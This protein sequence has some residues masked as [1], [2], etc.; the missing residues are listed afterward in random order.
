M[1]RC[2][3]FAA[4]LAAFGLVGC[5]QAEIYSIDAPSNLQSKIDSIA[6]IAVRQKEI[7]D[8]IAA[9]EAAAMEARLIDD[10]YQVGLTD[11]SSGWWGGHSKYYR[12]ATN[13]DTV[14]VKFKNFTGAKNV[15][16][17][18]VQAITSD[19]AR[20][21]EGYVEYAIWR[22]DNFSNYAWG[23][24]NG[25]GWNT[26]TAGDTH[27]TQQ[28]TSYAT[29][30]TANEDFTEYMNLMNGA[31]CIAS[32]TRGGDSVYVNVQMTSLS[33]TKLTKSFYIV[34]SGIQDKPIRVF[35]TLENCHLV[36]YKTL[37]SPLAEFTPDFELDPN[38]NSGSVDEIIDETETT[39][40]TYRADFTAIITSASNV[41]DTL[42]FFSEGLPYGGY[43][44]WLV[45]EGGHMIMNPTETYYC[46]LADTAKSSA[47]FYPYSAETKIGNVDNTSGW[48]TA[49]SNYTT[50]V[51]EGYF[52]YKFVNNTNGAA[53]WNN[54]CLYLTNG[55][56]R[57]SSSYKECFGMRADAW[58][59]VG[60]AAVS[61]NITNTYDWTNF[62]AN[63]KGATVEIS[64]KITAETTA[65]A[66][67][68]VKSAQVSKALQPGE[69]IK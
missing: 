36:F 69:T 42:T 27:G 58:D 39:G 11:N 10:V 3:L 37:K 4:V 22:A 32:I 21:G 60:Q 30:A 63:M 26:S 7:A 64:L 24:Q 68:A 19:V 16:C 18:W 20:G 29:M 2:V 33:G 61:G 15:W 23:T 12:L 54:W 43:G 51:G 40:S 59:N 57:N 8:S 25:T 56:S 53:N 14:Y 1:I 67:S 47:W 49:F 62:V 45:I 44:S 28:T 48:W 17:N 41:V 13:A 6:N 50:V 52:H 9:A 31:D 65:K 38:W 66:A 46:A 35:W 5:E 55:Q 34:E